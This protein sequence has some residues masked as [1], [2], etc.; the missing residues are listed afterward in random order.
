MAPNGSNWLKMGTFP[1][2]FGQKTTKN[3]ERGVKMYI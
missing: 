1:L 3:K 2:L